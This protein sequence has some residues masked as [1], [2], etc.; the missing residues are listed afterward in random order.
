MEKT[1]YNQ[2]NNL[3]TKNNVMDIGSA[4]RP[5]CA[6]ISETTASEWF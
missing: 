2:N 6:N 4:N 5:L 1:T 3:F